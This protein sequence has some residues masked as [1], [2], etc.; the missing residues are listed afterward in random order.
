MKFSFL[1]DFDFFQSKHLPTTRQIPKKIYLLERNNFNAN[2]YYGILSR[3]NFE[4]ETLKKMSEA[5]RNY[6]QNKER[7]G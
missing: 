5:R 1:A 7:P 3:L 2:E 4:T 6:W